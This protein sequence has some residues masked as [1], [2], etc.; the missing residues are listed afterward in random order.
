[1]TASSG[2]I[3][4]HLIRFDRDGRR[5]FLRA[6]N[7]DARAARAVLV[8]EALQE[9]RTK[10][11]LAFDRCTASRLLDDVAHGRCPRTID[12]GHRAAIKRFL[13]EQLGHLADVPGWERIRKIV[14]R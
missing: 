1:M 2:T 12:A 11:L 6:A 8:R 14:D 5:A 7:R 3:I 10:F 9:A 4:H 13:I